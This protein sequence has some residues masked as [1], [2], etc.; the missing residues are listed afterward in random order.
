MWP[1]QGHSLRSNAKQ[2]NGLKQLVSTITLSLAGEIS[3]N[4]AQMF[5]IMR[6][7]VTGKTHVAR[8]KVK[9]IL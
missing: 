6:W 1:D 4:F 3:N 8:S 5:N 2:K 7:I 9:V